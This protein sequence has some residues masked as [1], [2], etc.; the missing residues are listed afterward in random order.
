MDKHNE[1]VSIDEKMCKIRLSMKS[2]KDEERKE[3]LSQQ[4]E[5]LKSQR[6]ALMQLYVDDNYHPRKGRK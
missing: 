3:L 5:E 2:S 1:A 4:L 6:K